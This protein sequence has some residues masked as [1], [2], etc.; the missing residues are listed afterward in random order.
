[1]DGNPIRW[2]CAGLGGGLHEV[3]ADAEV[4]GCSAA[5]ADEKRS[6]QRLAN[7]ADHHLPSQVFRGVW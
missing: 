1:M 4:S 3:Q 6:T 5:T 2:Q 7:R